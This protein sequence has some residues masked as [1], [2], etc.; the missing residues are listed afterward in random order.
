MALNNAQ[1]GRDKETT[2]EKDNVFERKLTVGVEIVG[3]EF[4]TMMDLL[5]GIK[6]V[7]GNVIG[8]RFK[9]QRKYEITMN[10]EKGKERLVDGF[11]IKN[12]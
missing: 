6:E 12:S 8:C 3:E 4:I 11:K 2:T 5:K 1:A 10:T 7:C 9:S